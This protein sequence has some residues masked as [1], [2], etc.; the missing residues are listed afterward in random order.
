MHTL[1]ITGLIQSAVTRLF[2]RQPNI[3]D[4]APKTVQMELN[5]AHHLAC[6]LAQEFPGYDCDLGVSK[7][8]R[9]H[10]RPDIIFHTRGSSANDYLVVE[11]KYEGSDLSIDNDLKNIHTRW[12]GMPYNYRFGAEVNFRNSRTA[13]VLVIA[14]KS[15]ITPGH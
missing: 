11:V 6:E 8:T 15:Y 14:N 12:F 5:L 13:E 1:E 7:H 4:F 2:E 10:K 9:G 3:L